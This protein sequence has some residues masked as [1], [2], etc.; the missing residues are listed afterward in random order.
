MTIKPLHETYATAPEASQ[1]ATGVSAASLESQSR[2][3]REREIE[4]DCL[5]Q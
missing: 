5:S 3:E 1:A 4:I 2:R